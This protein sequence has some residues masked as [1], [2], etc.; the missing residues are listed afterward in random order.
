LD[1]LLFKAKLTRP[2]KNK[3]ARRKV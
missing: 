1:C 3:F 2:T